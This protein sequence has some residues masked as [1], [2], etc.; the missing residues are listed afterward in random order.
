[1]SII[2]AYVTANQKSWDYLSFELFLK[3]SMIRDTIQRMRLTTNM[4]SFHQQT[5]SSLLK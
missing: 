4:E 5:V 2:C 1:M 3:P